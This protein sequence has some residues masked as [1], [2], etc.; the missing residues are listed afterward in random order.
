M[1]RTSVRIYRQKDGTVPLLEWMDRLDQRIQD[2]CMRA[3]G[4]LEALGHELRRPEADYLGNGIHELR[5]RFRRV[6]YRMLYFFSGRAVVVISHGTTKEDRISE[7]DMNVAL[8]RKAAYE[9]DPEVHTA[10]M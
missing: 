7:R 2:K 6:N 10:P 3:V 9:S 1:P 4:R 5:V 8:R